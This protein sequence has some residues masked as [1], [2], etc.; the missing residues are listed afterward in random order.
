M[1]YSKTENEPPIRKNNSRTS[2]PSP[3]N[4]PILLEKIY[5]LEHTI[6][7]KDQ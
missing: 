3:S 4:D 5:D 6:T 2:I 1:H 7:L